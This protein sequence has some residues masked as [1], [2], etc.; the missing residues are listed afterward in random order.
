MTYSRIIDA[1]KFVEL[2]PSYHD[3]RQVG[4]VDGEEDDGK[5]GPDVSHESV[6]KKGG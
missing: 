5:H 4:S 3:S 6:G 1:T 2:L